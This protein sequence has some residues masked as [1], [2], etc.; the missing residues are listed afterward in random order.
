[1]SFVIPEGSTDVK[2]MKLDQKTG[3]F[4]D[5]KYDPITKEG[6]RIESSDP[7]QSLNDVLAVYIRDNGLYDEDT[8]LGYIKDPGAP[9][10]EY[11]S[12]TLTKS[13]VTNGSI[14]ADSSY[15]K[16]STAS[17]SATPSSG[18][19]FSAW[20]GDAS[21]SNNPLSLTMDSNKTVGA[22]FVED[23]ADSDSDGFTNFQEL[24][25]YSCWVIIGI[26]RICLI[27]N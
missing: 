11:S 20:S 25:T 13:S 10:S 22:T 21:G 27:S 18:Y 17:I 3:K 12:V 9:V 14:T 2:Y 7:T 26:C 15:K 8:R 5:F 24:V 1:M 16:N 4:F 19:A 6:A 23:T